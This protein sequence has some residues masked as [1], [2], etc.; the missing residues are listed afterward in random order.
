[1]IRPVVARLTC[2]TVRV[3]EGEDGPPSDGDTSTFVMSPP[4]GKDDEWH[5]PE[6]PYVVASLAHALDIVAPGE[7]TSRFR[8]IG[9]ADEDSSR[10]LGPDALVDAVLD[11]VMR[12]RPSWSKGPPERAELAS[13]PALTGDETPRIMSALAEYAPLH[14]RLGASARFAQTPVGTAWKGWKAWRKYRLRALAGTLSEQAVGRATGGSSL[15]STPSMMMFSMRLARYGTAVAL[16]SILAVD[17]ALL[18]RNAA[19]AEWLREASGHV[20]SLRSAI[21]DFTAPSFGWSA[22]VT[23]GLLRGDL[24]VAVLAGVNQAVSQVYGRGAHGSGDDIRW[25]DLKKIRH[26]LKGQVA[27]LYASLFADMLTVQ[28]AFGSVRDHLD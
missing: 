10:S 24:E 22:R 7:P 15:P 6:A 14:R 27:D 25:F 8:F 4:P 19:A 20:R 13:G 23:A 26:S 21:I 17:Y 1:M 2:Q 3:N 18:G 28:Q 12:L 5:I 9:L 11:E 16:A